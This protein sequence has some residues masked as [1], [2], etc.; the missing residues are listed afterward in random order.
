MIVW[1]TLRYMDV[2]SGHTQVI[3]SMYLKPKTAAIF[4][5][6]SSGFLTSRS[7]CNPRLSPQSIVVH[8]RARSHVKK[9]PDLSDF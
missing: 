7:V 6:S 9:I 5:G 1:W 2:A 4:E 8:Y 3:K